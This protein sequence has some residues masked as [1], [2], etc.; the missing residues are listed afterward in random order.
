MIPLLDAGFP[1]P[2]SQWNVYDGPTFVGELD[3]A[4]P[5]A[6]VGVELQSKGFHLNATSFERDPQKLNRIRLLGWNV[7]EFTWRFYVEKP[8]LLWFY[9]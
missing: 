3:L 2:E 9:A 8:E 1:T 7:L 6:K 4:W 5:A